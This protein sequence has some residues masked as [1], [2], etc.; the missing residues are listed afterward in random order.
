MI[1]S[2]DQ[3]WASK[4][5]RQH[6]YSDKISGKTKIIL[7]HA[8]S[9]SFLILVQLQ[10]SK[11]WNSKWF[12]SCKSDNKELLVKSN[13][14]EML[15]QV[16]WG[17]RCRLLFSWVSACLENRWRNWWS[18]FLLRWRCF[19]WQGRVK[20]CSL[21]Q[22]SVSESQPETVSA[23]RLSGSYGLSNCGWPSLGA[24][25]CDQ[26]EACGRIKSQTF[27]HLPTSNVSLEPKIKRK[28]QRRCHLQRFE[29]IPGYLAYGIRAPGALAQ[30]KVRVW[31]FPRATSQLLPPSADIY[32]CRPFAVRPGR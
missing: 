14:Q 7:W 13:Q 30:S 27:L 23:A 26:R 31:A 25:I 19:A 20:A 18:I 11:S 3:G 10:W 1:L 4:T 2:G 24:K 12:R 8:A 6:L 21:M 32:T 28:W 9:M 16:S 5:P 22:C 29:M 17:L 15:L